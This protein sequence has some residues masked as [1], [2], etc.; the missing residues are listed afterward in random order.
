M[1][2]YIIAFFASIYYALLVFLIV[3][4]RIICVVSRLRNMVFVTFNYIVTPLFIDY[5]QM[6]NF[7]ALKMQYF[8]CQA[9]IC[10]IHL[11]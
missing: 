1:D 7:V 3:T 4:H 8:C 11:P 6:R 10:V 2:S 5:S 9:D